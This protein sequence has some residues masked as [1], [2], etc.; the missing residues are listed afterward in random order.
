MQQLAVHAGDKSKKCDKKEMRA[1]ECKISHL[2]VVS[3]SFHPMIRPFLIAIFIFR[4]ASLLA[5][6]CCVAT[7]IYKTI[8][9]QA[10]SQAFSKEESR[11]DMDRF[12]I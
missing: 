9:L 7:I 6:H 2:C 4:C 1:V 3:W 11:K 12:V 5:F 8:Y 10:R